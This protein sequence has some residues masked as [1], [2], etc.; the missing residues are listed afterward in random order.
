VIWDAKRTMIRVADFLAALG[1]RVPPGWTLRQTAGI[2]IR[3]EIVTLA[4]TGT[5]PA[6][7]TQA[8]LA[9]APL[10]DRRGAH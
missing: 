5:N 2:A 8:W 9:K 3:G 6:G 1:T 10:S 7:E 4:G